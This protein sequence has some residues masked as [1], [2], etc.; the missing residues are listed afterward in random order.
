MSQHSAYIFRVFPRIGATARTGQRVSSGASSKVL[1][2]KHALTW[3]SADRFIHLVSRGTH[4]ELEILVSDPAEFIKRRHETAV[5]VLDAT[6][7]WLKLR[8]E[9]KVYVSEDEVAGMEARKRLSKAFKKLNKSSPEDV[10][11]YEQM[12]A[13]IDA[14]N[15]NNEHPMISHIATSAGEKYRVTLIN[16]SGVEH[17]FDASQEIRH[18]R[19]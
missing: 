2:E 11:Q 19:N 10:E 6:A 9:E 4:E 12:R 7:I 16:I 1:E 18:T 8:G 14:A 15:P 3:D 5:V 13:E 17:W